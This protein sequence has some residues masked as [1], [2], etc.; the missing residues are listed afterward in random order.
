MA[1]G[2]VQFASFSVDGVSGRLDVT[3]SRAE[4]SGVRA[5]LL[6]AA[7]RGAARVDFDAAKAKPYTLALNADVKNLELGRLF[8]TVAPGTPPT[9]EGRFEFETTLAGEGLNPLD[10]SLSSLGEFRLSGRD[11]VFRGLAADAGTGS[12]AVRVIGALTFSR[13]LQGCR[14]VCSTGSA[15][16]ISSRPIFA[17]SARRTRSSSASSRSCR[18]S[19]GSMRPATSSSRRC[20]PCC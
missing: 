17:S 8:A 7:L 15:R 13:E 6:G 2:K 9:A 10:L 18:R 12:K 16:F 5:S 4:L 1:L 3:P 14:D 20:G 19:S 11:G